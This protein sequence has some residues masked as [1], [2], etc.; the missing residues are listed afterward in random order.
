MD[1]TVH[2]AVKLRESETD[3]KAKSL[4]MAEY[5]LITANAPAAS[6]LLLRGAVYVAE[7]PIG[8]A[9]INYSASRSAPKLHQVTPPCKVHNF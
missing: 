3:E 2:A 1:R 7:S 6:G 5:N 8:P 9:F 4:R